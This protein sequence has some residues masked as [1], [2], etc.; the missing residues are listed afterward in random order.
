MKNIVLTLLL[1][2]ITI[3]R[4]FGL[5][6]YDEG[7][8][9]V[10]GIQLLQDYTDPLAYYYLPQYPRLAT[11]EDGTFE[12]LCIKYVGANEQPNGGLFHSLVEF[13]LP[14]EVI[15]AT[16]EALKKEV[17]GARI[18]G[19]VE[20]T[21]SLNDNGALGSF[22][23]VSSIL[24]NRGGEMAFTQSMVT[25]GHAP[26]T[27]NSKAVVAAVLN[28]E[29]AT[30]LWNSLTGPTSDVSVSLHAYYEAAV[31]GYNAVV[32]AAMSVVY[33]H[34]S[35]VLNVQEDYTKDE[36]RTVV[37]EMTR[38]GALQIEVLDRSEGLDI[39]A[40]GME[41]ILQLVTDKLTELMFDA[42]AGWSKEPEQEQ[43]VG[44]NQ[45]QGRKSR[46]FITKLFKG[47]GNQPYVTDNQ[48]VLK[49]IKNIRTNT[50]RLD[51]SKSTTIKVPV[52]TS[53]NL[54]GLFAE[55]ENDERYFRIV[56][57]ADPA[58]EKREVYFQVDGTYADAF[59]D[60]IN[61]VAVNFRKKYGEESG[62]EDVTQ[63][64]VFNTEDIVNGKTIQSA[65]FPR[66][67]LTEA[68]WTKYEMQMQWS[69]KGKEEI[70]RVPADGSWIA[71]NDPAVA[72]A[73]PFDKR[74]IELEADRSLFAENGVATAVV[75]F[76]VILNGKPQFL[77]K[78]AL[79]A[80]DAEPTSKMAV[81]HDPDE[82]VAYR[83]TWYSPK[84]HITQPLAELTSDYL[85]LVP[86]SPEEFNV[87]HN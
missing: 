43:A 79:R 6:K 76:A 20:L 86:P 80:S 65:I 77:T 39:D 1:I 71:A 69:I 82:P 74:M 58:F 4:T 9:Q 85:Y 81:Y 63:H 12:F 87:N 67:G 7:R 53:G 8:M 84:G 2:W 14:E 41:N 26:L 54:G 3:S 68:D 66:L 51:L 22:E 78:A 55:M 40:S 13:T 30:L 47:N 52:H 28:Q 23:V 33:E 34:F 32:N 64:F 15:A 60:L 21:Q 36:I 56:N 18:A 10:N 19:P 24:S 46:G 48:F 59:K 83:V 50:F 42:K 62:H 29:G 35:Q 27:P 31:K 38:N 16:E 44:K 70:V 61:F 17:P 49:D 11:K 57:L 45:I 72:L 73:P 37:D 75:D 25:S 5:V